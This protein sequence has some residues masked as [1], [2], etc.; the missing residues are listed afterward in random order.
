MALVSRVYGVQCSCQ[1]V[2]TLFT[3]VWDAATL[4]L[5]QLHM[6][7]NKKVHYHTDAV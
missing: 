4:Y 6:K 1:E 5:L 7:S 2:R 3:L